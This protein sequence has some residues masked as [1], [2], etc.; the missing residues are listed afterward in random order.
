M[1]QTDRSI[2]YE[3]YQDVLMELMKYK[4]TTPVVN[5]SARECLMTILTMMDIKVEKV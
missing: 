3:T 2:S 5:Y 4:T 1:I